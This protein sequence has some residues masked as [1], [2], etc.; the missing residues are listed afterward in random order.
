MGSQETWSSSPREGERYFL[1]V[2]LLHVPGATSFEYLKTFN[3]ELLPSFR[4]ACMARRLLQDDTEW[5]NTLEEATLTCMPKQ[6]RSLFAV[7]LTHCEASD[8]LALWNTFKQWMIEDFARRM[9]A[10]RAEQMALAHISRIIAQSNKALQDFNLPVL[11]ELPPVENLNVVEQQQEAHRMRPLLN[12]EQRVVAEA[13]IDKVINNDNNG[14]NNIFF[15]DGAGGTG[16][17]FTYNYIIAEIEGRGLSC[18]TA[19][20]TGIASTLL[21]NASTIHS[22][23]ALP[24]PVL[25]TSVCNITPES[26][27]G[28]ALR[29]KSLFLFDEASMIPVYAFN[30]IDKCLQDICG[31]NV[32]FGG[33]V[34]LLGGDFRQVLPVV[35]RG[36]PA[37]II[38][39]CIKSSQLWGQVQQHHLIHNMR[40]R[41]DQQLFTQ[42]LLQ[43]GNGAHFRKS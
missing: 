40:V 22:L 35:R 41:Q 26:N 30:C 12:N 15:L 17:T 28:Q 14:E 42:W 36:R 18:A 4:D 37:E 31:N 5:A 6:I 33:K 10:D 27:K 3:G 20:W 25:E 43:L 7:I 23:F 9:T 16:K 13:V 2:L 24:V 21:K 32:P 11:E 8:P 19:A 38:E 39:S 34:V 1:R 29:D